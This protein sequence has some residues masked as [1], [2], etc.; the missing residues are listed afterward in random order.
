KDEPENGAGE[1]QD[2]A[3]AGRRL[4]DPTRSGRGQERDQPERGQDRRPQ[5]PAGGEVAE[6][7]LPF[8]RVGGGTAEPGKAVPGG[9]TEEKEG[10]GGPER[11]LAAAR[12]AEWRGYG[13]DAGAITAGEYSVRASAARVLRCPVHVR[14]P[15]PPG[16]PSPSPR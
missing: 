11:A 10:G 15:C 5:R 2:A 13:H 9:A 16:V 4:T 14:A 3:G 7:P 1:E 12:I 8:R 6:R